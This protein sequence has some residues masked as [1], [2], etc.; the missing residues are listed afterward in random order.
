MNMKKT[1]LA[2]L[3]LMT[4]MTIHAQQIDVQPVP[5][6]I[7]ETTETLTLTG[8]YQF[9]GE[10]EANPYAINGLKTLLNSK[11]SAKE[12]I[13]IYIGERGDKAIRKYNK[14]IPKQDEGYF[15]RISPK[16]I[17]LAGND[18]QGTFYAVQ[19]LKQLLNDNQLPI[20]EITDY[21]E[22]RFRGVV[23]GFYGTPWSH[24]ARLRHLKFYG[25]NKMNTYI[26]GPKDDP[27]HSSPNWRL[28]YPEK[29]AKQIK[30]LVQ[31]AKENAVNFVWAIHPGQ[32]IK[33]NQEDR[34]N[35]LAKFEKM[36]ELGVR[37]LLYSSTTFLG[38]VPRLT[39]KPNS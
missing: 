5:Q 37:S 25:E 28:P 29:E 8:S 14:F 30:E 17:V 12:G 13:R 32:D 6:Q 3:C 34:D 7:K 31:V 35:L 39:S 15:L 16:E 24:Q 33:W 36:Y 1:F 22:V 38:K 23:E 27:Y 9:N 19:T 18:E 2:T 20:T 21:P 26:Y 11:Q 4:G 10:N